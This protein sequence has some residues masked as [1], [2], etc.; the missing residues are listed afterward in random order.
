MKSGDIIAVQAE[1]IERLLDIVER[2]CGGGSGELA[3]RV[4]A[5][6]K[7]QAAVEAVWPAIQE[8]QTDGAG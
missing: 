2:S 4:D 6:E 8:G 1:I 7:H 5:L 3:A